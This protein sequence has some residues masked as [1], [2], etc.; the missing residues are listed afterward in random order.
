MGQWTV[1]T[2]DPFVFV[3][4]APKSSKVVTLASCLP[5]PGRA[6]EVVDL[7]ESKYGTI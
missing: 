1:H 6:V 3:M 5:E 7:R 2:V 4:R